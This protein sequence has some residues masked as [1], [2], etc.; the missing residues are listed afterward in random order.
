ALKNSANAL[1]IDGVFSD[2]TDTGRLAGLSNPMTDLSTHSAFRTASLRE[3]K[4]T[5]PYMH[6]GQL[7]T[8][9]AVVSFYNAGGGEVPAGSPEGTTKDPLLTPLGLSDTE[10]ADLVEFLKTLS[11]EPVPS[12][13]LTAP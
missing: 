1:N 4:D 6:A 10:Q 5:A 8:L 13:L 11:G 12:S 3:V 7:E 2:K 9:E